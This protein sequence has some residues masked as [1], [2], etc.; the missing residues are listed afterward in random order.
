MKKALYLTFCILLLFLCCQPANAHKGGTDS[1]GGHY[2]SSSGE[3]HYHH[4]YSAH[5]H[6]DMDGD[7][8]ID[9]PYDFKDNTQENTG[10]ASNESSRYNETPTRE[11]LPT[12]Q[13]DS[14]TSKSEPE[15]EENLVAPWIVFVIVCFFLVVIALIYGCAKNDQEGLCRTIRNL[16]EERSDLQSQLAHQ[17]ES[18]RHEIDMLRREKDAQ[19]ASFVKQKDAQ[20]KSLEHEATEL[21]NELHSVISTL[22]IGEPYFPSVGNAHRTLHRIQIPP[23]VYLI[24]GYTPV[25]G[26]IEDRRPYGDLTVYV[27][28]RGRCY[29]T[30]CY[31]GS[32]ILYVQHA[33]DTIG[34]IPPCKTCAGSYSEQVPEWYLD[35]KKIT[36]RSSSKLVSIRKRT[37]DSDQL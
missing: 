18:F 2:D 14:Y 36:S 27:A 17:K 22:P 4:G 7:G 25:K 1:S 30:N 24:N 32:G 20:I 13:Q 5:S 3:Y 33:Y 6:Y 28:H 31:C 15:S 23:D 8:D 34:K 19:T 10:Y 35:L 16:S 26:I 21:R 29:H 12:T 11:N 9:C 37:K